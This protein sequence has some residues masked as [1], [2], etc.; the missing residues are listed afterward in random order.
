MHLRIPEVDDVRI[1]ALARIGV[2]IARVV[3]IVAGFAATASAQ[4]FAVR[5]G[6]GVDPTQFYGGVQYSFAPIWE[7]LR[8]TPS[9]DF[10]AGNGAPLMAV[11]I[12]A[13]LHSRPLG[14]RSAWNV[15]VGG[16]PAFNRYRSPLLD[17][18][19]LGLSAV[20]ALNHS[21]GWFGEFRL[22]FLDGADMRFNLGYRLASGSRATRTGR[23]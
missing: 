16:G 6:M 18:N 15:L 2:T 11:N 8:P 5:G 14:P 12:D 4:G 1:T 9:I 23:P 21:T 7:T 3:V 13:L 22:G 17:R 10:G 20:A 19:G